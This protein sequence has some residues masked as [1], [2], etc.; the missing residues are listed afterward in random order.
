MPKRL[1][2]GLCTVDALPNDSSTGTVSTRSCST[3]FI[4]CGA[5]P[6]GSARLLPPPMAL[7]ANE[8][9]WITRLKVSV[10]PAP[11][12]PEMTTDWLRP[13]TT[14]RWTAA[15]SRYTCGGSVGPSSP[16]YFCICSTPYSLSISMHGLTAMSIAFTLV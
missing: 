11:D 16:L 6:V 8:M 4:F 9:Y 1:E 3:A 10:L 5:A 2:F 7:V 14:P 12:S 13:R 15:A